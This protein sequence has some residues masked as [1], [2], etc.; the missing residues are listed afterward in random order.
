MKVFITK[1]A[2]DPYKEILDYENT[3]LPAGKHGGVVSFVGTMRDFNDGQDV[4]AMD[5]DYYPGMTERHIERVIQEA[6]DEWDVMDALVVHRVGKMVPTDPIVLVAVWSAHRKDSFDA[7]RYIINYL[8]E[9]APFWKCEVT[10]SGEK[11]WVEHNSE[12][13]GAAA[14]KGLK[15]SA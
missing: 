6:S 13:P 3:A 4:N 12:D 8:K 1:D 14:R 2:L 9:S 5:L 7:C 11:H 10:T 15:K